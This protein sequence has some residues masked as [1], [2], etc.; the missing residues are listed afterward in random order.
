[1]LSKED[2][3]SMC[4]VGPDSGMGKVLRCYWLPALLSSDLPD[5]D[6]DPKHVQL[7]GQD[8]VAFRD[9]NGRVGLLDEACCHRGASLTLGR[10]EGC[11]IRCIYHG[12]KFAVDGTVLETP[13]VP[14]PKFKSRFKARAYPV[15]EA[16]GF[17]WTYLGDPEKVPAFPA[18]PWL[19]IPAEHRVN[20]VHIEGCNFVQAIEGLLDSTHLGVL[21]A[22][23]LKASDDSG[24]GFANKVGSMK[25]DL[26]AQS[27]CFIC[28][29]QTYP[30]R[31]SSCR[32]RPTA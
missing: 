25:R 10:V 11:G 7:L 2:N 24:L 3:E 1:M 18:W 20:T 26:A 4:R 32:P 31:L 17:V 21:H 28:E 27:E 30:R 23:G 13:N 12:W 15:R 22:N 6:G 29:A 19:D 8:L 16:G 5:P 9:T 14:D